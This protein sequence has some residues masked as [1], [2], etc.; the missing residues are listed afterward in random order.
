M[1]IA[2]IAT[3]IVGSL[4]YLLLM[5]QLGQISSSVSLPS[6]LRQASA[7]HRMGHPQRAL[8]ILIDAR[9]DCDDRVAL[10]VRI[11]E[12][13]EYLHGLR[14]QTAEVGYSQAAGMMPAFLLVE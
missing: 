13:R 11:L 8:Q 14:T 9:D 6:L 4:L 2:I 5:R 12:Y 1:L 3:G 10:E 7:L